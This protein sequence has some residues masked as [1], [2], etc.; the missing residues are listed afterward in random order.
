MLR[1]RLILGVVFVA[2]LVGLCWLDVSIARPGLVLAVLAIVLATLAAGEMR[3]L[4][5][6]RG[7]VLSSSAV[8]MGALLPVVVSSVPVAFPILQL[9][10]TLGSAGWLAMGLAFGMMAAFAGE[11]RR[12]DAPGYSILN[13]AHASLSVLYIGGL[14]GMLVQLRLVHAPGE[15]GGWRGLYPLLATIATVKLSDIG[16]YVVGRT[17]GRHKLAPRISPGKTWEGA[18]GGIGLATLI[19]AAIFTGLNQ[20][21]RGFRVEYFLMVWAFT[22]TVAVAGLIGDLAES[23]L[24]RDAGVKDSSDWMP[25]F[26]GVLDLLDSILFAA[27]VA[28][29]WWVVGVVAP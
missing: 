10:P 14:I 3:R 29:M 22:L 27:P 25:G 26:G 9:N 13:V 12:Y 5:V 16:Q 8:Y 19:A 6:Q 23:L 21:S 24:K 11:M 28:Y 7:V 20:G 17:F 18:V 1:W 2:A 4:Y 15:L